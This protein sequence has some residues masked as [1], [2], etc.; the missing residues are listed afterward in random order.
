VL[1]PTRA[2]LLAALALLASACGG[3]APANTATTIVDCSWF[4]GPNCWT[5]AV[6]V[7]N[8]CTDPLA[9]GAFDQATT[10]CTYADG[11]KIEFDPSA[12]ATASLSEGTPWDFTVRTPS[13]GACATFVE[14]PSAFTLTTANGTVTWEFA[15]TITAVTC[16]D[17][18]R[19]TTD[20]A[21]DWVCAFGLL[22]PILVGGEVSFSLPEGH[23]SLWSCE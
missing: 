17:G 8:A 15:G 13:G 14:S 11:T 6:A 10:T 4:T 23:R 22:G 19:F 18:S 2:R 9:V 3:G 21:S 1:R 12:P 7:A 16:A 5:D 20:P